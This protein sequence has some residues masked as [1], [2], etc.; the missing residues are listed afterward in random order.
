MPR[1]ARV[2]V[3]GFLHHIVYRGHN[4]QP[5]P[6][7]RRDFEYYLADLQEWKQV[8]ELEVFSYCVMTGHVH[9]VVP[10]ND[11]LI[12]I[13]QLLEPLAVANSS[14]CLVFHPPSSI[15]QELRSGC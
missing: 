11:N 6:V 8:Y 9:L 14:S 12:A 5:V 13:F 3:P 2:I 10:A 15:V 1:Q 4:C 7:K